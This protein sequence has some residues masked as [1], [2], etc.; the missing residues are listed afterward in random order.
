MKSTVFQDKL[1]PQQSRLA[2][3]AFLCNHYALRIPLNH[4]SSVSDHH[5]K[6]TIIK[7]GAFRVFDK[8]YWPGNDA[9]DHLNFAFKFEALELLCLKKVLE[10]IPQQKIHDFI[11]AAPNGKITRKVWYYYES[12]TKQ[13][14]NIPDLKKITAIDLLDDKIFYTSPGTLSRRHRVNDNLLGTPDFTPLVRRTEKIENFIAQNFSQKTEE[15]MGKVSKELIGRAAS[16]LLLADS[17][18]SFAIE[19]ER[20]AQ[21]RLERWGKTILE[22]GR[23]ELSIQEFERLHHILIPD[24]RLVSMGLR[25][26]EVFIGERDRLN[27]PLPEFIGAAQK[28]LPLLMEDFLICHKHLKKGSIHPVLHAVSIAF[29]FVYIHPLQDGNGRLHRYLLH[30]ILA[31][32]G[33]TPSGFVFPISSVIQERINE[34]RS[35]LQG[36]SGP[37]MT[38]IEWEA[39]ERGNVSVLNDTSDLY[40]Y[41]DCTAEVEFIFSCIEQTIQVSLPQELSYLK[42]HDRALENIMN[43]IEMPDQL[44]KQFILFARQNEGKI[45]RKR[46]EKEFAKLTDQE[47]VELESIVAEAFDDGL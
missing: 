15:A 5:I 35:V 27:N 36:H 11:V 29:A 28:D 1:L 44:A 41:Y 31:D 20:P 33:F 21:N 46:R 17:Q 6:G 42:K 7:E 10:I 34:Y 40:R 22:A 13:K 43:T 30:H 18:A 3:W 38:L 39:T 47:I 26:E 14:L 12:L 45:S 24:D 32:R 16:F 23:N 2:G 8:R 4:P 37:L 9:I 25:Q 19:G